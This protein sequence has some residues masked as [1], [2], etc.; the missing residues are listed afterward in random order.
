MRFES[1]RF[2]LSLA[3]KDLRASGWSLWVFCACLA[4]GV[5]LVAVSGGLYQ[6][7]HTSLLDDKRALMG[8]DLQVESNQ[9]LPQ[10]VLDW[11]Q[12]RGEVSRVIEVDTMLG[13]K[14]GGFLRVELQSV[15]NHYPLYGKLVLEPAKDLQSLT[16]F[17]D[18]QWGIA[19]DP[20]LAEKLNIGIGDTVSIGSLEMIV[21]A[22]VLTQPNRRLSANWRGTPVLLADAALQASGLIQT[23][24]LIEYGY[25]VRTDVAPETWR[26]Q[27]YDAFPDKAWEVQT[28]Q[29]RSQRISE[30]LGQIASALIIIGF[31]SLFIGGLGVFNSI[32]AYLQG[33]RKTIA[34]LRALGLRNRRLAIVY[35]LQ[36]GLLG[37]GASLLGALIGGGLALVGASLVASEVPLVITIGDL[38]VPLLVAVLF[39]LL[40]AYTFSLPAISRALSVQPATLF[41]GNDKGG[42]ATPHRWW[43]AT[44]ACGLVLILLVFQ[45]VPD[46]LF[47]LGFVAVVGLLLVLLEI[48]VRWIKRVAFTLND[49][50]A[51]SRRFA[52]RLAVANLHRPGSPL[53]TSLLSLGTALTLLVACTLIVSSLVRA[54]NDTIPE[55]APALVLYDINDYQLDDVLKAFEQ[56]SD[57]TR[58]DI[59]PL[60]DSRIAAING[61]PLDAQPGWSH[62]HLQEVRREVYQLSD[63]TTNI[64]NVTI[65][66]G[67]WW[68]ESEIDVPKMALEDREANQLGLKVGDIVTFLIEGQVLE[69]E[70]AAIF[71]QKGFQTRF[72]FEGILS[73]GALNEFLL[74]YVGAAYMSETEAS[75]A[76]NRIATVAPNVVTVRT[77]SLLA[78]AREILGKASIGLAVVASVSFAASVLV[79]ISVMAAGRTRQLYDATVLHCLGTKLSVIKHSLYLEYLLFA[80]ITSTFAILL[81][82]AIALPLLHLRMKLPSED[83]LWLGGVTALSVSVISLRAGAQYLFSR[84]KIQPA[85]LLRD[86]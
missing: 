50:P 52:L 65:V 30:R 56:S 84:L 59:A 31:S 69:V 21:R 29:N 58:I 46:P 61:K 51:F 3:W 5:T 63:S 35:L 4:L 48:I 32:Q 10:P 57:T 6:L 11:M 41:R 20:F 14:T 74:R 27:F 62:E 23:G 28:F 25:F 67:E 45:A 64:D 16:A 42:T 38:V 79:L 2:L 83:L 1:S 68:Q 37:G 66:S 71:S 36:V 47:G 7:V 73:Q 12:E 82:S 77:A 76:Q 39:G 44:G 85:I 33:K 80:L 34:T 75:A 81:G 26:D 54:I 8:G 24:S 17:T 22:L 19:I 15:D 49:H 86:T 78:T 13:V 70:V 53:R 18:G 43:W 55:E 9:P 72:W 60:V 40:T